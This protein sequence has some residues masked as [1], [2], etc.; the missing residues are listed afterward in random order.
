[1][2]F[3]RFVRFPNLLI[4][5][6]SQYL[7]RYYL[8]LPAFAVQNATDSSAFWQA[9]DLSFLL[10]VLM[11]VCAAAAGY[12]INDIID[13][14]IDRINKPNKTFVGVR[15]SHRAAYTWYV[16]LVIAGLL[17]ALILCFR[18]HYFGWVLYYLSA[19][20]L[21]FAYSRWLKQRAFIGNLVVSIFTACVAWGIALPLSVGAS[22]S[23]TPF[24]SVLLA[25]CYFAF[26]A[27]LWREIVKDMEDV[28]GD[29]RNGCSTLPIVI[30]LQYTKYVACIA[31][32]FLL[33]GVCSF[34]Y[35]AYWH[36]FSGCLVWLVSL[37]LYPIIASIYLLFRANSK[38]EF[39]FI[40]QLIKVI[41]LNGLLFLVVYGS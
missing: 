16:V 12:I 14:P 8:W 28:A 1:M 41:M 10:F 20:A 21:L 18:S 6:I 9:N 35:Q 27:N 4:V 3:L 19:S 13:E 29:S 15:F 22:A 30:G 5:V 26:F 36:Q 31:A 2:Q 25:Y 23:T 32:L 11:T 39:H 24:L 34:I 37:V 38:Q 7:L 40:S 33:L 17:S